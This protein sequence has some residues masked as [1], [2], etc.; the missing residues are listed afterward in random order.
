LTSQQKVEE[1]TSVNLEH[2]KKHLDSAKQSEV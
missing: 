2:Q 1:L